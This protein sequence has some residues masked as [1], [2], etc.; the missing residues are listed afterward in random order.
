[1]GSRDN[2]RSFDGVGEDEGDIPNFQ[3]PQRAEPEDSTTFTG[4]YPEQQ[5]QQNRAAPRNQPPATAVSGPS[6]AFH[7]LGRA[8]D[9]AGE[10]Q[11]DDDEDEEAHEIR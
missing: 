8:G 9:E 4:V 7:G 10:G 5:P 6:G 11:G 3:P 2:I 1:M